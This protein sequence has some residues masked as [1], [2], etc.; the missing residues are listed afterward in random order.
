M[1]LRVFLTSAAV[2]ACFCA[3]AATAGKTSDLSDVKDKIREVRRDVSTLATEKSAQVEQLKKLEKQYGEQINALNAVKAEIRQKEQV[4][5]D[6][7][8]RLLVMQ[9]EIQDQQKGLH[10]LVKAAYAMSAGHQHMDAL[11]NQQ[12][13]A[14]SGRMLVYY[15][16]LSQARIRRL[17]A[18]EENMKALKQLE[19]QNGT[20]S[21]LLQA[22]L[23]KKLRE[24]QALQVVK[25]QREKLLGE[26]EHDYAIKHGELAQLLRNEHKLS[27]L[28]SSLQDAHENG[29][30]EDYRRSPVPIKQDTVTVRKGLP[31]EIQKNESRL[32]LVAGKS[33][34]EL[35]GQLPWPVQGA[36]TERF[37]SRRLEATL[38]GAVIG[39]REGA[40]IRA[41]ADGRVVYADWLRGYG[42]ML[43]LDHGKG[44][45]SLYAFNQ[46]L[47]KTVGEYIQAGD[48]VASVG[49]SGGRS[50]ASL[51]FGIR[52]HGRPVD[53]EQWCRK[54][55]KS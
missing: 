41:V 38:D 2:G 4:L 12:D 40:D 46:S 47:Y 6:V 51:Y 20:E 21:Q 54:P 35:Q 49:R 14:V 1:I 19:A 18:I 17:E 8:S 16:Y 45:M 48:R 15:D 36:I 34:P 44:F 29:D 9:K 27:A 23:E 31:E 53:P 52:R 11:L 3:G 13:L 33:F 42:L 43:I 28:V 10:G 39:A 32:K 37:G 26:I 25:D 22:S 55:E 30:D 24:T 5:Q 50:Q 7:R